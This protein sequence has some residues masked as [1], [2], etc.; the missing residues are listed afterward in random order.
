MALL[1]GSLWYLLQWLSVRRKIAA[2]LVLVFVCDYA[3]M[4][5]ATAPPLRAG[6]MAA[7]MCLG[8]ILD[9]QPNL[10]NSL[11]L[12]ALVILLADPN[13]V[14]KVGFQLSFLCVM[15]IGTF[16]KSIVE[17]APDFESPLDRLE[18][19][20]RRFAWRTVKTIVCSCVAVTASAQIVTA[21]LVAR[22]F[23]LVNPLAILHNVHVIPTAWFALV[24]GMLLA[25]LGA[26]APIGGAIIAFPLDIAAR[27]F[28][29]QITLTSWLPLSAQY[30]AGPSVAWMT[31]YFL[32]LGAVVWRRQLG[33]S[34]GRVAILGLCLAVVPVYGWLFTPAPSD[35]KVT[36]FDVGHGNSVLVQLPGGRRVLYDCGTMGNYDVGA[37]I[38][39]PF[40]WE[41]GVTRLDA[42]VLSHPHY[43][44]VSGF[45][46]LSER[47]K[48]GTL[49]V[50][51]GF[52]EAEL[53]K[54]MVSI[55]RRD[56][57][58]VLEAAAGD[59]LTPAGVA[60]AL[61]VLHPPPQAAVVAQLDLN[62]R[63][64]VLQVD[65][66]GPPFDRAQGRPSTGSGR[67]VLLMGDAGEIAFR[68]MLRRR[69]AP[70]ADVVQVPHHGM[71]AG[72]AGLLADALRPR[73]ALITSKTE[74]EARPGWQA[75][76]DRGVRVLETARS[77]A[78]EI[79]P[80]DGRLDVQYLVS[81]EGATDRPGS[82]D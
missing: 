61:K 22:C 79:T 38:V 18:S 4:T 54:A 2:L 13:E 41:Q 20:W 71:Q 44:H 69:E 56:G 60:A 34:G 75:L 51:P 12:A 39:A 29:G 53:G 77:G 8:V 78:I 46:G 5:G 1:A 49:V 47:I 64:V 9:R 21:P 16:F 81:Q 15:G 55:A 7:V 33:L 42:V 80:T 10:M 66:A 63:S 3:A 6:V 82:L 35:L 31:A 62:D 11:G 68:M 26:L 50:G 58:P 27:L 52:S 17:M 72:V 59:V 76:R 23:H 65:V 25:T 67:R 28:V 48:V 45:P 40:L 32:V 24:I 37:N 57:V 73:M 36:C 70:R 30:V 19:D 14:F 74:E 43:D